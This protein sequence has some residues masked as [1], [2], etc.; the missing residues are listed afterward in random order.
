MKKIVFCNLMMK[1]RLNSFCYAVN[2]N[3]S[4]EY[5][6]EV[7]FPINGVLARVLKKGDDVKV[8]LLK[9]EDPDNNSTKNAV[10]FQNELDGITANLGAKIEYKVLSVPHNENSKEQGRLLKEIIGELVE[11]AEI[12]SDITYGSKS[13]PIIVFSALSFAERF[14]G[15]DIKNIVYGQVSF[16]SNNTPY[17]PK[18]FD[19]TRLFYLNVIVNTM[20]CEDGEAAKKMLDAILSE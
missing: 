15:A 6:G 10:V 18:L 11:G 9:K 8:V 14:F 2:G 19:M 16:D 20:E 17:D 5:D 1:G 7:I 12:Y 13:M 4:I 3:S